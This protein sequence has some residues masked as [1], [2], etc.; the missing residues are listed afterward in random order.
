MGAL[1]GIMERYRIVMETI[2]DVTEV[3]IVT[4]CY[5]RVAELSWNITELPLQ[6]VYGSLDFVRDYP[7]ES[8]PE[9]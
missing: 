6:P 3:R 7:G 5:G 8:L 1:Q 2:W 4:E 9:G